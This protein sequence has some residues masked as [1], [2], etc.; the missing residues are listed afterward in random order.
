MSTLINGVS[1]N[2]PNNNE[3]WASDFKKRSAF[4]KGEGIY[5]AKQTWVLDDVSFNDKLHITCCLPYVPMDVDDTPLPYTLNCARG[6]D[7]SKER[8]VAIAEVLV[9]GEISKLYNQVNGEVIDFGV[10]DSLWCNVT[11]TTINS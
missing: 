11:Y 6:Y 5:R 1:G 8:S 2:F 7:A 3:S 9:F 4:S 10:S